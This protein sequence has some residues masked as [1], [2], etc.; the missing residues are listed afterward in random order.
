MAVNTGYSPEGKELK[1]KH[2]DA[3]REMLVLSGRLN[4]MNL[5]IDS[6]FLDAEDEEKV[7]EWELQEERMRR[8]E[9]MRRQ[10]EEE[11]RRQREEEIKRRQEEAQKKFKAWQEKEKE[12]RRLKA[13]KEK[14][15]KEELIRQ[16]RKKFLQARLFPDHALFF[17]D[18]RF[19]L[20][21]GVRRLKDLY[22]SDES[23]LEEENK[24]NFFDPEAIE[25]DGAAAARIWGSPPE[26][27]G[28]GGLQQVEP[29]HV[30]VLRPRINGEGNLRSHL[31]V[32]PEP[33][34]PRRGKENQSQPLQPKPTF[35]QLAN[36]NYRGSI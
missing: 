9:E 33:A 22:D 2:I 18:A 24:V 35:S 34:R 11:M 13:E 23:D 17:E 31:P 28:R 29:L 32:V 15:E 8:K 10:R 21:D 30:E 3:Q 16:G 1:A 36:G 20:R 6:Q 19:S 4:Q 14:E 26:N 25:N 27:F 12:K 7:Q 5:S